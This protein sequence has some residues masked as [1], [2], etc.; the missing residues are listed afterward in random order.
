MDIEKVI[1]N[2]NYKIVKIDENPDI[3]FRRVGVNA[4]KFIYKDTH[5]LSHESHYF[6]KTSAFCKETL[7][8]IIWETNNTVG[9]KSVSKMEL[10]T[11]LNKVL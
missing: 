5:T 6:I 8:N 10:I 11:E 9:P 3:A 2:N 4:G 1:P 7:D